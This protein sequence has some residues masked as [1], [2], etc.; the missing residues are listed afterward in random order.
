MHTFW[1]RIWPFAELAVAENFTYVVR[2]RQDSYEKVPLQLL[3]NTLY[4]LRMAV[5]SIPPDTLSIS[6][7]VEK[8]IATDVSAAAMH[9]F[10][11]TLDKTGA[12]TDAD[13]LYAQLIGSQRYALDWASMMG[14]I[15]VF[16]RRITLNQKSP[17]SRLV[18]IVE[19]LIASGIVN[20]PTLGQY[21]AQKIQSSF[22][23]PTNNA[24]WWK[25]ALEFVGGNSTSTT[26]LTRLGR[27]I[28]RHGRADNDIFPVDW[29][30]EDAY[31]IGTKIYMRY[32]VGPL[33]Q[34]MAT[35][36]LELSCTT[37][38]ASSVSSQHDESEAV[39]L[40]KHIPKQQVSH[41]A[42]CGDRYAY[43]VDRAK[44]HI[45]GYVGYG[46][47]PYIKFP[48]RQCKWEMLV[49]ESSLA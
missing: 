23:P 36:L 24:K 2:N 16:D 30:L 35:Y 27:V 42:I 41:I 7:T 5:A 8:L 21:K 37:D 15:S 18:H 46:V 39:F 11:F 3:R 1:T 28:G 10:R 26:V 31:I 12:V 47:L 45:V 49:I 4:R 33:S 29:E 43:I 44:H 14:A 9:V 32:N 6:K 48:L 20:Q 38:S 22:L 25:E 34:Q 13:D 40:V 19:V 17:T